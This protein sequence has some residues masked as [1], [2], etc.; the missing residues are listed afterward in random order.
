M[1]Q[2]IATTDVEKV[3]LLCRKGTIEK[4]YNEKYEFLKKHFGPEA[5]KIFALP[6]LKPNKKIHWYTEFEGKIYPFSK[7]DEIVD[8]FINFLENQVT[9]LY[10]IA[11]NSYNKLEEKRRVV[12]EL[13]KLLTIQSIDD[14]YLIVSD[15]NTRSICITNWCQNEK[16]QVNPIAGL[17]DPK[18]I[19]V[20]LTVKRG[21]EPVPDYQ[22]WIKYDD[23]EKK[24][25]TD[26]EGQVRLDNMKLLSQFT[27][28]QRVD[29]NVAKRQDYVVDRQ[30]FEFDLGSE[31]SAKVQIKAEDRSGKPLSNIRLTI[32]IDDKTQ[33]FSTDNQGIVNIGEVNYGSEITV[34]QKIS[35]VR[36]IIKTYRFDRNTDLPI[37]F[38]GDKGVGSYLIIKL[39]DANNK[40]FSDAEVEVWMGDRRIVKTTNKEGIVVINDLVPTETIVVRHLVDGKPVSQKTIEYNEDQSEIIFRSHVAQKILKNITIRLLETKEKPIM[41]LSVK[42]VTGSDWQHSV[43]DHNGYTI[44][45][46]VD[47]NDNP[48]IEFVHRRRSYSFTIDCN[49]ESNFEFVLS[50]KKKV[51]IKKTFW[52]LLVAALLV[53]LG[54]LAFVLSRPRNISPKEQTEA[55][56]DSINEQ[57]TVNKFTPY[58]SRVYV[59][60]SHN[61]FPVE[62]VI[63]YQITDS[64]QQNELRYDSG[65]FEVDVK[66][67]NPMSF[68]IFI[69]HTDTIH[70]RFVPEEQDTIWVKLKDLKIAPDTACGVSLYQRGVHTYVQTFR[71]PHKVGNVHFRFRKM[72]HSDLVRVYVGPKDSI[73][74]QRLVKEMRV[75]SDTGRYR[76]NLPY[77]DSLVTFEIEAGEPN[78]PA[79]SLTLFCK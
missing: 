16:N 17:F 25:V 46:K 34:E 61:R 52:Y 27:V 79:W 20:V 23:E 9:N 26:S 78:F 37:I 53:I 14:V 29:G 38:R 67:K 19:N 40:P 45:E 60:Y 42:L 32:T 63:V 4:S 56:I 8:N 36:R 66:D 6:E 11:I 21:T 5:Y 3:K 43:T 47:C 65:Y 75:F 28:I 35:D 74:P 64:M 70:K 72:F 1:A 7:A 62:N 18:A 50:N 69:G 76:I 73:N 49:E 55:L 2:L 77:P 41:N 22:I 48:H 51:A 68:E 33:E 54:V 71:F 10:T 31:K 59:L 15:D 12:E 30:M 39:L 44:F 13:D 57:I 58:R 24:Y